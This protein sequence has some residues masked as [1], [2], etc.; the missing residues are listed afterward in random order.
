M[1]RVD[2][3]KR[4]AD[5]KTRPDRHQHSYAELRACCEVDGGFTD[6]G[7]WQAHE[8]IAARAPNIVDVLANIETGRVTICD[9]YEGPCACG[10]FH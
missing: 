8:G 5:I 10:A 1:M 3:A 7:L 2:R 4:L 6:L 9:V